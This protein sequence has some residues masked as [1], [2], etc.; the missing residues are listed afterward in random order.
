M[1]SMPF[2]LP[3]RCDYADARQSH[4]ANNVLGVEGNGAICILQVIILAGYGRA[5]C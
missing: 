2:E 3:G 4:V 5:D 1:S